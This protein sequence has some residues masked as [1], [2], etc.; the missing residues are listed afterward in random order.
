[1]PAPKEGAAGASVTN[2]P[3][4]E[5]DASVARITA[6]LSS[7]FFLRFAKLIS[8]CVDGDLIQALVLHAISARATGAASRAI[9]SM[10]GDS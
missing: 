4:T 10:P 9:L 3:I 5:A 1:M 8:D 7:Q 2:H 6:R